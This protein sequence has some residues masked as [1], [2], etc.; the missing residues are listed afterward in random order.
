MQILG[1]AK[2]Q[3]IMIAALVAVIFLIPLG[4]FAEEQSQMQLSEQK[5]EAGLIY[6]FLKN[7][8]WPPGKMG[9]PSSPL[10]VCILGTD[11]P[12]NGYLQPIE[13]RTVNQRTIKLR[14]ISNTEET[15]GCHML[16]I[17]SDEQ[18]QWPAL[19]TFLAQKS[20]LTVGDFDGFS[21]SGGM[22]EF[23]TENDHI[24]IWLNVEA[25][26]LSHLH[27]FDSL[28]RLAKTTHPSSQGGAE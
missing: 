18:A 1:G 11:D 26:S 6:N 25:V 19:H 16:F 24:Q 17:G 13:S 28:R 12:F 15:G 3:K 21:S 7:T 22:I 20:V 10:V 2:I 9:P 14:H 23:G 5:I 27:I 4:S 8:E